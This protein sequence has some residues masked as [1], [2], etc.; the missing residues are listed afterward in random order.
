M[1]SYAPYAPSA[2]SSS[3]L[4]SR[5]PSSDTPSSPTTS[6]FYRPPSTS[7][8]PPAREYKP[9]SSARSRLPFSTSHSSPSLSP[10]A[11]SSTLSTTARLAALSAAHS[12]RLRSRPPRSLPPDAVEGPDEP[13]GYNALGEW[14]EF[15]P[16]EQ[17][18][19]EVEMM[20][21]RKEARWRDRRRD[22]EAEE[23][24][25][26]LLEEEEEEEEDEGMDQEEPPPDVL[27]SAPPTPFPPSLPSPSLFPPRLPSLAS[28]AGSS[29]AS[30]EDSDM[31]LAG[32]QGESQE[33]AFSASAPSAAERD[34][35]LQAFDAALLGAE[36][37]SCHAG[38][39]AGD[40]QGGARCAGQRDG[41]GGGGGCGW[42]IEG[43]VMHP[44]R[45][46]FVGHIPPHSTAA[47][48]PLI[49]HTPFTGTLV[50]CAAEGCDESF[51][52]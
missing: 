19:L 34:E 39:V 29:H 5:P 3:P 12:A 17:A 44:L 51:G 35:A 30:A 8:R 26:D 50:L 47:H 6:S 13:G 52:A 4:P 21:A 14:E 24:G 15:D 40:G 25:L 33:S 22:E 46:V 41:E 45:Q 2:L 36:C 7:R 20:Q 32:E 42:G 37:P 18:R 1:H 27:Y 48:R 28:D 23:L 9:Q 43:G 11:A 31:D 10:S 49:T 38:R 16:D